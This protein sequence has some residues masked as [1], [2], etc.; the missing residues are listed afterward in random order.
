MRWAMNDPLEQFMFRALLLDSDIESPP[1]LAQL[2]VSV[3]AIKKISSR[4]LV[5]SEQLLNQV[6]GLLVLAHYRTRPN[7]LRQLLDSTEISIFIA[8][9]RNN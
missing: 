5:K 7:D 6:F 3:C 8:F 9:I 1:Q 4:E 2:D